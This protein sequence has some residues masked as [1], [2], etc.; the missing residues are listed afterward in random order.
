MANLIFKLLPG[1]GGEVGTA[2]DAGGLAVNASIC[3][4]AGGETFGLACLAAVLDVFR[5]A[6]DLFYGTLFP[7]RAKIGPNSATDSVALFFL[8]SS[9]PVIALWGIGIRRFE[10]AG[11]A[12]SSATGPCIVGFRRLA[13]AV[14]HDLVKQLGAAGNTYFQQYTYL[15]GLHNPASNRVAIA[16]RDIV[17]SHYDLAVKQGKLD[18]HTGFPP[19]AKPP[20]PK[21]QCPPGLV[22]DPKTEQCVKPPPAAKCPPGLVF[23]P[24]TERCV[25]PPPAAHC[26]PG[27][28][29]IPPLCKPASGKPVPVRDGCKCGGTYG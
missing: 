28:L 5:L 18:P 25:K 10:A 19:V 15:S 14:Q 6:F 8:P 24:K 4:A 2:L 17:D 13:T 23:D 27:F 26:P 29:G 1:G 16:A 9:N 21:K 3:A 7:S 22:F 12:L 11:C 20:P